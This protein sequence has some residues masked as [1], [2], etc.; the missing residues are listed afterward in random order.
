MRLPLC[1]ETPS[2]AVHYFEL[3]DPLLGKLRGLLG[4]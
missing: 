2:V 3:R 4:Q 1:S